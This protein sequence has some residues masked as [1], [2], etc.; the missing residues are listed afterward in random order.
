MTRRDYYVD[1]LAAD[2][3]RR[4]YEVATPRVRRYMDAELRHVLGKVRPGDVVLELG[5]GYGRVLGPLAARAGRVVG[6]DTS[7]ASLRLAS[8][9]LGGVSNCRLVLADAVRLGLR[10]GCFDVVVCIQNGISA[11]HVDQRALIEESV[12]VTKTGGKVLFSSYA[13]RFWDARLDWFR[14]QA[15]H[16]L[17]GEINEQATR[18]G[19]I[20]CKDGFTATTVGSEAFDALTS[21]LDVI[22]HIEEVD[23][24]SLF[25][26][27]VVGRARSPS[28]RG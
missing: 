7:F 10:D 14:L 3:L 9:K 21:A 25:C 1:K 28:G 20:V 6:I 4:C 19:R 5:C 27:M 24:S 26:E 15:E 13:E 18:D 11:F 23:G 8:K 12:R 2:R 16:G 17:I 22:T